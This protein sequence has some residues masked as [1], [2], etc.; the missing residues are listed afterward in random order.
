MNKLII[1]IF[2]LSLLSCNESQPKELNFYGEKIT[3]NNIS[4]FVKVSKK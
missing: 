1:A 4:D 2:L 3:L